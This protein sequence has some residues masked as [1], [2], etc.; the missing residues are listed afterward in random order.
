M[1]GGSPICGVQPSNMKGNDSHCL[2]RKPEEFISQRR[3]LN[4]NSNKGHFSWV[5]KN[6]YG[7]LKKLCDLFLL[8]AIWA[9]NI[10][11]S[12][13][14][15]DI[16]TMGDYTVLNTTFQQ[17]CPRLKRQFIYRGTQGQQERGQATLK[18]K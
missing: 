14:L 12:Y 16:F 13:F 11:F 9:L 2:K 7:P 6:F 10:P 1:T 17:E 4:S 8:D 3:N 15:T 5:G 18:V